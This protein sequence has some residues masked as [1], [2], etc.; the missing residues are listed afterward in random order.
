MK[1]GRKKIIASVFIILSYVFLSLAGCQC[2]Q[3][4]Q[5]SNPFAMDRQTVPPP[6]TFSIQP[7]YLGQSA[8]PTTTYPVSSSSSSSTHQPATTYPP[9]SGYG[10]LNP[11]PGA[12]VFQNAQT[13]Q[14][15]WTPPSSD[16]PQTSELLQP[17]TQIATYA[18]NQTAAQ[19]LDTQVGL[20]RSTTP[21]GVTQTTYVNPDSL[22]VSSAQITTKVLGTPQTPEA[23]AA[24]PQIMYS[25]HYQ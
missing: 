24:E 15:G 23:V 18:S 17:S 21:D 16:I 25:G 14:G 1:N 19:S 10:S 8:C 11:S 22:A 7:S 2:G 13:N 6:A 3:N 12:S 9:S 4:G 5:P 20:V